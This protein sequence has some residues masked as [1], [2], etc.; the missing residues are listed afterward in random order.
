MA[1][2]REK[3]RS[4][5]VNVVDVAQTLQL[6][7]SGLRYGYFNMNGKQYQIIGQVDRANRDEPLLP[8][9]CY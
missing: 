1:S 9:S 8:D 2:I 3:A 7:L 5:D 4:L 6:S